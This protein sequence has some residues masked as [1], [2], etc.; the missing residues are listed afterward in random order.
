MDDPGDELML[1]CGLAAVDA[2]RD[3]GD[4]GE[5]WA[6]AEDSMAIPL[7]EAG[8]AEATVVGVFDGDEDV[9]GLAP[10]DKEEVGEADIVVDMVFVGEELGVCVSLSLPVELTDCD[11]DGV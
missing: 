3:V 6:E 7:V 11:G 9:L 10:K 5:G 4:S 2:A 8:E 1:D